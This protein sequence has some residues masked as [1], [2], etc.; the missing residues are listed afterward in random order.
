M[1]T[2]FATA[3]QVKFTR[4]VALLVCI[5][6]YDDEWDAYVAK[7]MS[8]GGALQTEGAQSLPVAHVND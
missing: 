5:I 1:P 3:S 2:F 4:S 6:I 7:W 8:L